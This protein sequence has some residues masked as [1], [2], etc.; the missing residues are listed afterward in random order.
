MNKKNILSKVAACA[1]SGIMMVPIIAENSYFVSETLD[2]F[3]YED[4]S[5]GEY[6]MGALPMS[7]AEIEQYVSS[8][9]ADCPEG[10]E[11]ILAASNVNLPSSYDLSTSPY[12]PPI[13][14][15]QS[16]GSCVA[17]ATTYYQ[18]TYEAHKLNNIITTADNAYS[19]RF[20]YNRVNGGQ[21]VG[22][23]LGTVYDV[24]R[25]SGSLTMSEHPYLAD[26]VTW[27]YTDNFDFDWSN[28]T[29]AMINA[30]NTRIVGD[31]QCVVVSSDNVDSAELDKIRELLYNGKVLTFTTDF[32]WQLRDRNVIGSDGTVEEY[33]NPATNSNER[34]AYRTCVE[35][36]SGHALTIVGYDDT[37]WSDIN[38]NGKVD[39]AELGAFKIANSWGDDYENDG[40]VWVSY[41][42]LRKT[43]AISGDWED[44]L[45]GTRKP[46]FTQGSGDNY[47]YYINVENE[48][49][50]YV[51]QLAV[52]TSRR[53]SLAISAGRSVSTDAKTAKFEN[54]ISSH[55]ASSEGISH[56]GTL[57]F[58]Y[59]NLAEPIGDYISGY[60]WYVRLNG[61]HNSSSFKITDNLSN[62]IVDFG[63]VSTGDSYMPISLSM[64]DLN[65]DGVVNSVDKEIL[66]N[67]RN[68]NVELSNLQEYLAMD[69]DDPVQDYTVD[70]VV[71]AD[72]G[73]GKNI[74]VTITNTG[75]VAIRNWA[76]R[77][78]N[79]EGTIS[80]TWNCTL[81]GDDII[82]NA[83]YN[84]DIAVGQS[85]TFGYTLTNATGEVPVYTLCTFRNAK[86]NGYEVGFDVMSEWESGFVGAITIT[87]TT[88]EPIMAWE[89]S[90][91]AVDFTIS[92]GGQ[93]EILENSGND[94]TITGTYNGNIPIPANTSITM[95][96]NG[97]KNGTP[98]ISN[99]SMTEM[100]VEN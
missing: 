16:I 63:S 56:V 69:M 78:N 25:N 85:V 77:C 49:V 24:L 73:T 71:A 42:T 52:D 82:K 76:L 43:T 62:T 22:T 31:E 11:G 60:N 23:W 36:S 12:F 91:T 29:N 79:F 45:A 41:D 15:Q 59:D 13:G 2:A 7:D 66:Y 46:V 93:F 96:F 26:G 87:N 81:F 94:Y 99:V 65:Y 92:G 50:Y 55:G 17:W 48:D 75:D 18:F 28:D 57:V 70:Y 30:L 33:I 14:N 19:P 8:I 53:N 9:N 1:L 6:G 80:N 95:Q 90:F 3:A 40:Y 97:T 44:D 54:R 68:N 83:M 74:E 20:T 34:I 98:S 89:L 38:G 64:G 35:S 21:N 39:N 10:T 72:W 88:S 67:A 47:V 86:Q 51:G 32:Y 37:V 84:S 58:D 61:T 100:I 5:T 4:N 27:A